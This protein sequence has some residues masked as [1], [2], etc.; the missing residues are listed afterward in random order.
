MRGAAASK[1]LRNLTP[2]FW[3]P[4]S[5]LRQPDTRT[6][7]PNPLPLRREGTKD[8]PSLSM[9]T[10]DAIVLGLGGVGSAAAYHLG[11]GGLKVL[12]IDQFDPP[13]DHGSSH[14]QTRIIRQAYFEHAD[15]VPLALRSYELWRELEAVSGQKLFTQTGLL[16]VGPATGHVVPGVLGSAERHGLSVEALRPA[17]AMRRFPCFHVPDDAATAYEPAA[18]ALR[19]EECVAAHVAAAQALGVEVWKDGVLRWTAS[20]DGV[21]ATTLH[22]GAVSAARLVIAAGPWSFAALE[23]LNLNLRVLRKPQLW[24]ATSGPQYTAAGRCP[25]FLFETADG[26]YYGLPGFDERG[27]KAAEHSGGEPVG[28]PLSVDRELHPS[29]RERVERFLHAHLP[30]LE[31]R[32]TAHAVCMYTLSADEHFI[33]DRHPEWKQVAFAAGLSGHGFK[34]TPVLGQALAELVTTGRTACPIG[35]LRADRPGLRGIVG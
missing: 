15:Y 28:D 29:D 1:P 9:P 24:Y 11:L 20:G 8:S 17:E 2:Y 31:P 27:L 6:P 13:H 35:F 21:E 34:F 10:Y 12:G 25:A 16:Q 26:V 22:H 18:G 4:S 30:G 32:L 19:V 3:D 7:H 14:G 23:Q 33:V 5:H